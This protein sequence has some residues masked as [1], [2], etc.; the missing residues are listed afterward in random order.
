MR[1]WLLALLLL[2]AG[3]VQAQMQ[4]PDVPPVFRD[5]AEEQRFHALTNELRCVMCQNQ[6]LADSNAM[7]ARDLR[8]EVL[9]LMH[10][11][12]SDGEI[13]QFLVQR[14]GEFVLYQP[15]MERSTWLLWF[16]PL[17]LVLIAGIAVWRIIARNA[18]KARDLPTPTD[19]NQEW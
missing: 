7:V 12:K 17:A 3:V 19:D 1:H 13:K 11:G 8:R 14:Y 9:G 4:A 5:A 18:A 16:G 10:E 15:R 2:C 6:S